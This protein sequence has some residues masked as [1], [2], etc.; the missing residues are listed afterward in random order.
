MRRRK[1][2]I[3]LAATAMFGMVVV[4]ASAELHRV[5]VKLTTGEEIT[6][7]VDVPPGQTAQS[8]EIPGLPAPVESVTDLGPVE[9]PTP[10]PEATPERTPEGTATP[11]PTATPDVGQL[12]SPTP[13]AT[14]T[15]ASPAPT[16]TRGDG[17]PP[18]RRRPR[19]P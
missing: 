18:T 17:N 1:L 15:P 19:Q 5:T 16:P 7:T 13:G 2:V 3:T 9:T 10:T 4:P 8:I 6:L 11:S 12:P 14:Q